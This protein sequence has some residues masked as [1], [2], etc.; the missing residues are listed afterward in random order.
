VELPDVIAGVGP[1]GAETWLNPGEYG[2]HNFATEG[3]VAVGL[4]NNVS[5]DVS[6][7]IEVPPWL[8]LDLPGW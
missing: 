3:G 5:I 1:S 7:G 2:N 8:G 6:Y 4:G